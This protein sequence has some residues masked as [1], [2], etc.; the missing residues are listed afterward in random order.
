MDNSFNK[1]VTGLSVS[2]RAALLKKLESGI[3]SDKEMLAFEPPE[4][5]RRDGDLKTDLKNEPLLLRIWFFLLA[6]FS[7]TGVEN[8]YNKHRLTAVLKKITTE[9]PNLIDPREL[10]FENLFYEYLLKLK[11]AALFFK[12][13]I[14]LYINSESTF[15]LFVMTLIMPDLEEVMENEVS[16]YS[17]PAG[18][19]ATAELRASLI[20]RMESLL[21]SI[22]NEDKIRLRDCFLS[23]EWLRRFVSLPFSQFT[24]L[25]K[26]SGEK[27]NR[28]V[29]A[30][31][32]G[33]IERFAKVLCCAKKIMPEVLEAFYMFPAEEKDGKGEQNAI[34]TELSD[35]LHKAMQHIAFIKYFIRFIPMCAIGA[36]AFNSAL[37]M[38][39]IEEIQDNGLARCK[40]Y[41]RKAF[42][43]K[44]TTWLRDRK[45]IKTKEDV[46]SLF[47]LADYPLLPERP[48]ASLTINVPCKC[49]HTLGF[50]HAFFHSMYPAFV[51][52]WDIVIM[53]GKFILPEN[54]VE[55]TDTY[56]EM[57]R[58]FEM[59]S[60]FNA[61]LT[62]SGV[63]GQLFA[64]IGDI[65][66]PQ[67]QEKVNNL[68]RSI[69]S[70]C[71]SFAMIFKTCC[72]SFK[73]LFD[74]M[75]VD[76]R[77]IKYDSLVNL[78]LLTDTN[79]VPIRSRLV[80]IAQ[81]V[82]NACQLLKQVE[83]IEA[84]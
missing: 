83:T 39:E 13:G 51:P 40:A 7:R 47:R 69:E 76:M 4:D 82:E 54:R 45:I 43:E 15:S 34:E 77:N 2:E 63:Y 5:N 46:A 56:N 23:L 84:V 55:F 74:G 58:L 3:G 79:N 48:W 10:S 70:E 21:N 22:S 24:S 14:S 73:R 16:P 52:L 29:M 44:W 68:M 33:E 19:E 41:W 27:G 50:L 20:R 25:F 36:V 8:V 35:F 38:P 59:L 67:E 11:E 62:E 65:N 42:D 57:H 81:T 9:M 61:K 32:R 37:W 6:F 80:E 31:A 49:E 17:I 66:S 12:D 78:M 26:T 64:A 18:T 60:A 30:T 72:G 75:F 71:A 1:L 28:C 53:D